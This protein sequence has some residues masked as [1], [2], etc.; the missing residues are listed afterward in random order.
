MLIRI[1]ERSCKRP[2]PL[3]LEVTLVDD[4]R[5]ARYEVPVLEKGCRAW[6]AMEEFDT[7]GDRAH[8]NW[9]DRFFAKIVARLLPQS[10]NNGA[11]VGSAMAYMVRAR[12]WLEFALP[13]M[14]AFAA[15]SSA[16]ADSLPGHSQHAIARLGRKCRTQVNVLRRQ[17]RTHDARSVGNGCRGPLKRDTVRLRLC[18]RHHDLNRPCSDF[19]WAM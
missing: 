11:R 5:V 14:K 12:G 17:Q 10:S 3:H 9:P 15:D 2:N 16:A 19:R 8:A 7:S 6:P 13:L 18:S 4:K 1:R